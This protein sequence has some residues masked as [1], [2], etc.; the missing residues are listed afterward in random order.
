MIGS[1]FIPRYHLE[2]QCTVKQEAR[3][4]F[5]QTNARH[6]P[7]RNAPFEAEAAQRSDLTAFL[8]PWPRLELL[9]P[10]VLLLILMLQPVERAVLL[11]V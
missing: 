10:P 7:D 6:G 9:P 4:A 3:A 5:A 8:L 11:S 1:C 2:L